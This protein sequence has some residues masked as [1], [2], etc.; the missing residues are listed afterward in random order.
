MF[1]KNDSLVDPNKIIRDHEAHVNYLSANAFPGLLISLIVF[2]LSLLLSVPS[3]GFAISAFALGVFLFTVWTHPD[4]KQHEVWLT[5]AAIFVG[6][7]LADH[8]RGPVTRSVGITQFMGGY[9]L[10]LFMCFAVQ[11]L[12]SRHG[13]DA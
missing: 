12:F 13:G 2:G 10:G 4:F 3:I 6:V 8:F 5:M 1:R 9:H 11:R 7:F